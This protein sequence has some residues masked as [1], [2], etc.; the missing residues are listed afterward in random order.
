[1]EKTSEKIPSNIKGDLQ[2]FYILLDKMI[3][4]YKKIQHIFLINLNN[5]FK[6]NI[7]EEL[8]KDKLIKDTLQIL[9]KNKY[10]FNKLLSTQ[11]LIDEDKDNLYVSLTK[12]LNIL[13]NDSIIERNKEVDL[14]KI[15][16]NMGK[17]KKSIFKVK[18][19][20]EVEQLLENHI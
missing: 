13:I 16:S 15:P 20:H 8:S 14:F 2:K 11:I 12:E 7:F 9:E 18:K 5:V 10:D 4:L 3:I 1:M 17:S 6:K 19:E